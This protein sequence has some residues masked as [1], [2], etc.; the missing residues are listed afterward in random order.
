MP[1]ETQAQRA[2]RERLVLQELQALRV[3]LDLKVLP[4]LRELRGRL[5][6]LEQLAL[7]LQAK[8]AKTVSG[9]APAGSAKTVAPGTD[10]PTEGRT[11][12]RLQSRHEAGLQGC[13]V[14]QPIEF[15]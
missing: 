5:A 15:K 11:P 7:D 1:R 8:T 4:E 14:G 3:L 13:D 10:W 6:L 12:P 9:T 2:Q